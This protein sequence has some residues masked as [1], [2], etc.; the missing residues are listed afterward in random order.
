[1]KSVYTII[2]NLINHKHTSSSN[3]NMAHKNNPNRVK[4]TEITY[5]RKENESHHNETKKRYIPKSR[6]RLN[7]KNLKNSFIPPPKVG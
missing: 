1:M 7:E 3:E 6:I 4:D 2:K 5:V